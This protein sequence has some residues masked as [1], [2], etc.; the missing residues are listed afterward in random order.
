MCATRTKAAPV[1]SVPQQPQTTPTTLQA[2]GDHSFT[3]QMIMELQKSVGE[4]SANLSAVKTSVDSVK[5]K[6]DNLV[7]W[8]HM[9]VGGAATLVIGTSVLTWLVTKASDYFVLKSNLPSV[10]TPAGNPTV[11]PPL[12]TPTRP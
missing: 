5:G 3:L 12:V 9:I 10:T 4:I 7:S 1:D 6:V 8:K 2:S 11:P